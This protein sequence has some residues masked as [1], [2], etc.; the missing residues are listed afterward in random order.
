MDRDSLEF[1]QTVRRFAAQ[2]LG[3]HDR[4][5]ER[6]GVFPRDLLAGMAEVGLLG[7]C[8]PEDVGGQGGRMQDTVA[9]LEEVAYFSPG[10]ASSLIVHLAVCKLLWQAGRPDQHAAYLAP[11][12]SGEVL[13]GMAIT[14]PDVGSDV[15]AIRTTARA[16]GD[17]VVINGQKLYITNGSIADFLL[18]AAKT[19]GLGADGTI[20][21]FIV[22]TDVPG[23]EVLSKLDKLGVRASDTAE[24]GFT[25]V[26][27]PTTAVLGEG[28]TD[29]FVVAQ[30]AFNQDRL[31]GST[32][33]L[34]LA[35]R[36]LDEAIRF[37]NERTQFGRPI[38]QFQAVRHLIADL[39]TELAA[40]RALLYQAAA[41]VDAGGTYEVEASMVKLKAGQLVRRVTAEAL[42]LHG[43]Q[44]FMNESTISA[45][46]RHAPVMSI[47]G[48]TSNI[49]REL[50]GRR[51]LKGGW[52]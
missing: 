41:N 7:A 18:V 2:R 25:D 17:E 1:Q 28:T 26:R 22:E 39:G 10:V 24:I 31:L 11:G 36:A 37:A 9:G 30:E 33:A 23:F 34:G 47:A 15:R 51:M 35:R 16:E 50:I 19:T 6:E 44:G 12:L 40:T 21:W 32:V 43:G 42:E 20:A 45:L 29:G 27:V 49:Q 8:F 14:E 38:S 5:W 3:D 46:Y 4:Q 48:G 13:T 52:R